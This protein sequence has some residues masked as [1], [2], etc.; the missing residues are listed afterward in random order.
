MSELLKE[1]TGRASE[2]KKTIEEKKAELKLLNEEFDKLETEILSLFEALGIESV[3]MNDYNFYTSEESSVKTPKTLEDK[4]LLFDFL[5]EQG[6][7]NEFVSVNSQTLNSLYK[8]LAEKALKDGV[9]EFRL[10]GVGA[11]SAYKQLKM[12]KI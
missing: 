11:P 12:R 2:I 6:I 10:P 7:F 1:K 8:S 5:K 9:L 4:L 3:K